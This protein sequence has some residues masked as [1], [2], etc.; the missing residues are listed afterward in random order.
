[1][2][3]CLSGESRFSLDADLTRLMTAFV[4][5]YGDMALERLDGE[6]ASFERLQESLQS[7]PFLAERKLVVM[8]TPGVNKR[9]AEQAAG[10]LGDLPDTTDVIIVE[11]K[12]DKRSS[13]YKLLKQ[14]TDFREFAE[15]DEAGLA[16]WLA[17]EAGSR[18]GHIQPADARFLIER[19]GA[20]QQLLSSELDKLL[21]YNPAVTRSAIELLSEPTPQSTIFELLEAAFA[22]DTARA[23]QLYRDQR[24]QKVDTAQVVAML[25]WQLRIVA[26]IKTAGNRPAA[27]IASTAKLNPYVVRKTQGIAQGLSST[28]LKQLVADLLAID[29]RSKRQGIDVDE[30]L[31]NYLLS[32]ASGI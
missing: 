5:Q 22:G 8:R 20:E 12:L 27:E 11:P 15:P 19:L 21:L 24:E 1:M 30:A 23:L 3:I 32:L 7:L 4:S 28:R 2:V 9:F 14:K 29:V 16:S 13:Y 17:A 6:T 10:L 18:G 31:Q 26:L 25:T